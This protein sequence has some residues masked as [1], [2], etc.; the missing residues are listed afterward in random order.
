MHPLTRAGIHGL[1]A[2][3][4]FYVGERYVRPL[5]QRYKIQVVTQS[6]IQVVKHPRAPATPVEPVAEVPNAD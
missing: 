1:C 3:L 6:P 5:R 4:G 2:A